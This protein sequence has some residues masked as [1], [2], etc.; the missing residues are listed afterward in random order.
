MHMNWPKVSDFFF[1]F[2]WTTKAKQYYE[3]INQFSITVLIYLGE[4]VG[5][6]VIFF[7]PKASAEIKGCSERQSL[8]QCLDHR[9]GKLGNKK[10]AKTLIFALS[11][12]H[13]IW[14]LWVAGITFGSCVKVAVDKNRNSGF[15]R[16]EVAEIFVAWC[17]TLSAVGWLVCICLC[18]LDL[19]WM[20]SLRSGKNIPHFG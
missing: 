19:H 12:F 5:K 3:S 13:Y 17:N 14:V 20:M 15:I 9:R 10:G 7:F 4:S 16:W 1:I 6:S 2:P 18:I 11:L 8:H